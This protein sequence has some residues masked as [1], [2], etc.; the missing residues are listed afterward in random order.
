MFPVKL[1]APAMGDFDEWLHYCLADP[2]RDDIYIPATF[3]RE[4]EAEALL[5]SGHA[6]WVDSDNPILDGRPFISATALASLRGG[7]PILDDHRRDVLRKFRR[8]SQATPA[9]CT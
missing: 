5:D 2:D 6:I 3:A 7:C 4:P 1:T 9:F 8:F